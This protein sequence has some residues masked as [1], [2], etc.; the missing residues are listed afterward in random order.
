MKAILAT[1]GD[2]YGLGGSL[3]WR[4]ERID[5]EGCGVVLGEVGVV[6]VVLGEWVELAGVMSTAERKMRPSGKLRAR[7]R[8][9][10]CQA[11]VVNEYFAQSIFHTCTV[12]HG[13]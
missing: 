6:G 2:E 10:L 7:E 5:K 11:L 12:V 1:L 3:E 8:H 13:P 9:R 4:K